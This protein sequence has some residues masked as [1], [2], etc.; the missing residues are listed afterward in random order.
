MFGLPAP[1]LLVSVRSTEE[2]R[3]AVLGGASV[4]DVKEPA[5][6]PLGCA[7]PGTWLAV[8]AEVPREIPVTV[9]LGELS[10]WLGQDPPPASAFEGIAARK[11]GLAGMS[12]REWPR[13]WEE[14]RRAFGPGPPWVAVAYLDHDRAGSPPPAQIRDLAS[15]LPGCVGLLLDTWEKAAPAARLG[16]PPGWFSPIR[17][18]GR[19]VA[20]AGGIRPEQVPALAAIGPDVVA[21][22]GAAC[23]GGDRLGSVSP[24]RVQELA[25]AVASIAPGASRPSRSPEAVACSGPSAIG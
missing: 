15:T 21:V 24:D 8:R 19:F 17:D 23:A 7:D 6:G 14:V 25:D 12:G 16:L 11:V 9:A 2:A 13:L 5:R 4:I 10:D 3:A 20:L 1:A 18:S 22:R